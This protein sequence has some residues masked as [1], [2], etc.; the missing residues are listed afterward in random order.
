MNEPDERALFEAWAKREGYG[1]AMEGDETIMPKV[2]R[3]PRTHAAW[4]AW[5]ARAERVPAPVASD[6]T[7]TALRFFERYALGPMRKPSCFVCGQL[8]EKIAITHG[9]LPG[10]VVCEKC[11]DAAIPSEKT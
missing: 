6:S 11:R 1:T 4:F 10:I 3:D 2:Y 7:A 9:D 5:N 8:P